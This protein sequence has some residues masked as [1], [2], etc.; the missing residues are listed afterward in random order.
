[1][2]DLTSYLNEALEID[3]AYSPSEEAK[4]L[5]K[6]YLDEKKYLEKNKIED[7]DKAYQLDKEHLEML[8]KKYNKEVKNFRDQIDLAIEIFDGIKNTKDEK[9]WYEI[10]NY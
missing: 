1:M 8:R 2:K 9:T 3:E 5:Y 4:E 10:F 6:N 7:D